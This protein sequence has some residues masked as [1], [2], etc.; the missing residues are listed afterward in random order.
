MIELQD[1]VE[2]DRLPQ[3]MDLY[4][5]AWWARDRK[6][7][8]V[9]VMLERSTLVFALVD[10]QADRLVGFTR[11]IT[12]GVYLAMVL[13]V[14]VAED[15]RKRGLGA[16]LLEAVLDHPQVSGVQASS[17]CASPI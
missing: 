11:V 2:L 8:D 15:A 4:A 13:D 17:W 7:Q 16:T 14:I 10:R 9:A 12:D 5:Q 1:R 6:A 3:L